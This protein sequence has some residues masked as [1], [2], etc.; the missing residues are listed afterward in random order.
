MPP[1]PSIDA[2]AR[3]ELLWTVGD[4]LTAL[5][6]LFFRY[7]GGP[8]SVGQAAGLGAAVN[9][10]IGDLVVPV[11]GDSNSYAG[12]RVTAL[13][14][15]EAGDATTSAGF[16]GTIG[17]AALPASASMVANFA[18][19]RRYRGGR[20]RSYLPWGGASSLT[21]PQR[22]DSTFLAE[23]DTVYRNV[24]SGILG[25]SS[26]GANFTS[27]ANVS[28]YSG[29]RVVT[30]PVTGRARNVPIV[31]TTP[32]VDTVLSLSISPIMGSQR[33]RNRR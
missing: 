12:C 1:L 20:P 23:A 17:G 7:S 8:M 28:Y 3:V 27:H 18:I 19:G 6:R 33:R 5:T 13:D 4:D 21:T 26:G 2:V 9:T 30:N 22:W 14:S 29:S 31:R 10:A 25:V 15:A 32:I 24:M 16:D 11:L